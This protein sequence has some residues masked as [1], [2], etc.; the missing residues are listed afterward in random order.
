MLKFKT[1]MCQ[2]SHKKR[3]LEERLKMSRWKLFQ[4]KTSNEAKS[5][6]SY[7]PA[8]ITKSKLINHDLEI[9]NSFNNLQTVLSAWAIDLNW[10]DDWWIDARSVLSCCQVVYA[11]SVPFIIQFQTK[12]WGRTELMCLLKCNKYEYLD[13]WNVFYD[14]LTVCW[15]SW[16]SW[17]EKRSMIQAYLLRGNLFLIQI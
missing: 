12:T 15:C 11:G 17:L 13:E 4:F 7:E 14:T 9:S 16:N 2:H 10:P 3:N 1:K 6:F 5:H 8:Q